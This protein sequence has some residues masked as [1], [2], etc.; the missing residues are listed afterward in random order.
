MRL[1]HTLQVSPDLEKN[2]LDAAVR[3]K[4]RVAGDGSLQDSDVSEDA[5]RRRDA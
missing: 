4:K 3:A 5:A 2:R 1:Q